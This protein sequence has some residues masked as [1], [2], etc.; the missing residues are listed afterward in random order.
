MIDQH[1]AIYA[2]CAIV[3]TLYALRESHTHYLPDLFGLALALT[4]PRQS[5][6]IGA[7]LVLALIRHTWIGAGIADAVPEWLLPL[8]LPAARNMSIPE[9]EVIAA[10]TAY[11]NRIS[12]TESSDGNAEICRP[13][14]ENGEQNIS[15]AQIELLARLVLS[16][17]IGRTEAARAG[18]G[19]QNGRKYQVFARQLREEIDRQQN[20]YVPLDSNKQQ[21]VKKP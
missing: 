13:V 10:E 1:Y 8:L 11:K 9:Q 14:A 18:C 20:H 16:G 5:M 19:A 15:S 6:A 21:K 12:D 3:I 2:M 7:V 4:A 17:A